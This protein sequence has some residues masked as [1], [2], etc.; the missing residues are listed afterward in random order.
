MKFIPVERSD[1]TYMIGLDNLDWANGKNN[2]GCSFNVLGARLLNLS[3][4]D[5]LRYLRSIGADLR[6]RNGYSFAIFKDKEK[7]QS[8]C[9][10]LNKEW[11][12]IKSYIE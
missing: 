8:I 12:T 10:R 5:Y 9:T 7:C 3:Y 1:S 11:A 4:P 6:G 2:C